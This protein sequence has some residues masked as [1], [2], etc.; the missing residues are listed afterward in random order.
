M[1]YKL[2]AYDIWEL[3]QRER[4]EDS[5]FPEYGQAKPSDRLFI[6]CDGM[7]GHSSG[8]VAS[9]TVCMA[10]SKTVLER[11]PNPEGGFTDE[12]FLAA[13][14]DAYDALDA[15]DDGAEK[16][17]GTT[18]TFLKFHDQGA[19]I[20]H[21][22]DSRV[23]HIRPG[24]RLE[25]TKILFQTIDH[26]V[27]NDLV[28]TGNLTPEEAKNSSLKNQISRAMQSHGGRRCKAD[29]YHTSDIRPGDYFIM[30]SDG[31]LESM[32]DETF[33]Y[34]FSAEGGDDEQKR[35][36]IIEGT[37]DNRDNHSAII[38]HILDD[39]QPVN[40]PSPRMRPHTAVKPR[41]NDRKDKL[42]PTIQLIRWIIIALI[43]M[44]LGWL[45]YNAFFD[46]D[47]KCKDIE[48]VQPGTGH[49]TPPAKGK[50]P[51]AGEGK[52]GN[53][54]GQS[55]AAVATEPHE[56]GDEAVQ[57]GDA[58]EDE[59]AGEG[60]QD[61]H[62]GEPEAE[63]DADNAADAPEGAAYPVRVG[64]DDDDEEGDDDADDDDV[65]SSD[66]QNDSENQQ[67]LLDKRNDKSKK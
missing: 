34:V 14:E 38:V 46:K 6:L 29:I 65:A 48:K 16:K 37:K 31:I 15:A 12:D 45:G 59:G 11:C 4:Q 33:R 22:G 67:N 60:S 56:P 23:Y 2:K 1:K 42:S 53:T 63:V 8:N 43:V 17:M 40:Q 58:S 54:S 57:S 44:L 39:R 10:M 52:S 20:A 62:E 7:G 27:V 51:G 50:T 30:C 28:R 32:E 36:T 5:I 66:D 24:K 47:E 19:T 41:P 18:L 35:E 61:P 25:D 64:G 55:G 13:L 26:S 9:R 3:G 49:P 21:I